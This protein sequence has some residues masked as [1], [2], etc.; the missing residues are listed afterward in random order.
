ME[1]DSSLDEESKIFRFLDFNL[2]LA[3]FLLFP[4]F[5]S[6][7]EEQDEVFHFLDFIL[8]LFTCSL[9]YLI[10]SIFGTLM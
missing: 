1:S 4:Q 3:N 8:L 5:E 7:L 9:S 10:I 6:E 2:G